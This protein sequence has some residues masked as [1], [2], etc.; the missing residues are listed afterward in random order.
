MADALILRNLFAASHRRIAAAPGSIDSVRR[1]HVMRSLTPQETCALL[2]GARQGVQALRS[3][4]VTR[5]DISL[6]Q[7]AANGKKLSLTE[8]LR[9]GNLGCT[10][11]EF[12][13]G[14]DHAVPLR[15]FISGPFGTA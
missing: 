4:S 3:A 11:F 6:L 7:K 8:A 5:Y 10:S 12:R 15:R 2:F 1:F 14:F 9:Q 13:H